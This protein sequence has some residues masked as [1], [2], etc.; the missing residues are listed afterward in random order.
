MPTYHQP[1]WSFTPEMFFV[2]VLKE[3]FKEGLGFVQQRW[4]NTKEM[5]ST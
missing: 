4:N 5:N 3:D 2:F 1:T